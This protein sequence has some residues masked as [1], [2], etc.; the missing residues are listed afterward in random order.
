MQD[1]DPPTA[2]YVANG[3]M[4]LGV[5]RALADMGLSVPQDI[6][7]VSTD[8]VAGHYGIGP[9]L[10][11]TEHPVADMLMEAVRLLQNRIDGGA[12][13]PPSR[14]V[15]APSLVIGDSCAPVPR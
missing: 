6:S 14:T 15:F 11:R 12:D 3:M 4:A 8:T 13:A 10:T 5:M 7:I 2:L 9:R 1:G